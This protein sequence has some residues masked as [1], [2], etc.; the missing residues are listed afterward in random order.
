M[1]DEVEEAE[2]GAGMA[3][4]RNNGVF[5]FLRGL[6]VQE[7]ADVH[8]WDRGSLRLIDAAHC[9]EGYSLAVSLG[10]DN[11]RITKPL[12]TTLEYHARSRII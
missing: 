8:G 1:A 9:V 11:R 5:R 12:N 6:A 2:S 4:G 3:H 7:W 10:L